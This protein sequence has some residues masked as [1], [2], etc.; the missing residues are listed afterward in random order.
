VKRAKQILI[1][2]SLTLDF[3]E[4][5]T[6]AGGPGLYG[7][8]VA[9]LLGCKAL[10]L[11][12]LGCEDQRILATLK[13]FSIDY[14]GPV[15]VGCGYR[16]VHKYLG[17][18]RRFSKVICRPRPLSFSDFR[19]LNRRLDG[20]LI[21]PV[22][23]EIPPWIVEWVY[24]NLSFDAL[25]LDAQGLIRCYGDLWRILLPTLNAFYHVSDDDLDVFEPMKR[26]VV[27]FTRG[28][29]GG[30]VFLEG[31]P[32]LKLPPPR[33]LVKDPTGA[34]DVFT[35]IALCSYLEGYSISEA[36][37]IASR[38]VEKYLPLVREALD[39]HI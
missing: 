1:L 13:K 29:R 9:S 32:S 24:N 17:N 21:S 33:R 7:G 23:C 11:G 30:V 3:I 8:I 37:E 28:V 20:I 5:V 25:F 38:E 34:G 10:V 14:L 16:F 36:F 6:R 4:G 18:G 2:G 27:C 22:G 35:T 26:G 19:N 12:P 15:T 31:K 39:G